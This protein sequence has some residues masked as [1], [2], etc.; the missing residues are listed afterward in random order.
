VPA[1][2]FRPLGPARGGDFFVQPGSAA[3]TV[4]DPRVAA[5][6]R[7]FVTVWAT[8]A[9]GDTDVLARRYSPRGVA[10]GSAIAVSQD[11]PALPRSPEDFSPVV[12][13]SP[14]GGFAVAWLRFVPFLD[15]SHPGTT[16]AVF[17]RRFTAEGTPRGAALQL[18]SGL[19]ASERPD[20][21]VTTSGAAV[22]AWTSVDRF[23]PFEP[24]REGVSVRR[25]QPSGRPQPKTL[26]LSPPDSTEANAA[27]SC[28]PDGGYAVA[29]SDENPP[30]VDGTDVL[31]QRFSRDG[32]K[33]GP[34]FAIAS[35][36]GGEQTLPALSH[37]SS[38]ALVAAWSSRD[39]EQDGVFAR[40]FLAGGAATGPQV[41]VAAG[42]GPRRA[43]PDVAH[44]G[45]SGDFVVVWV[46]PARKVTGQR[47]KP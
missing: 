21:C 43:T 10:L 35:D 41:A 46:D 30:A 15:D 9:G 28:G 44:A 32:R 14:D 40:R 39:G 3:T 5:D 27:V 47:F 42:L 29:W 17:I 23:A 33:A 4:L 38:G 6:A 37:D 26:V 7:S 1:R 20:L 45:R 34:V 13:L 36:T 2:F 24:S 18:S 22:V 19:V 8:E 11:D 12:A 25:L 31:A 16:P